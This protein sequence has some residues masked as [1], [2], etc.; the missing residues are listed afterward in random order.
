VITNVLANG[1]QIGTYSH[2][3]GAEVLVVVGHFVSEGWSRGL[4]RIVDD[5]L[6]SYA[7]N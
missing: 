1:I 7:L 5:L 3:I 4:G 2:H 6:V